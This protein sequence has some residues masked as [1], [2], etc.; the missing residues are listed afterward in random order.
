MVADPMVERFDFVS[1]R[2]NGTLVTNRLQTLPIHAIRTSFLLLFVH[3]ING[4]RFKFDEKAQQLQK[5][6][7]DELTARCKIWITY[8][9]FAVFFVIALR[10]ERFDAWWSVRFRKAREYSLR[11]CASLTIMKLSCKLAYDFLLVSN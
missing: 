2:S 5:Q 1:I 3:M 8:M 11:L 7:T 9:K 10:F 4:K 6:F